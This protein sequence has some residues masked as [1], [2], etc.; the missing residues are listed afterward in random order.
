[1]LEVIAKLVIVFTSVAGILVATYIRY[2]KTAHSVLVCPLHSSCE[3]VTHSQFSYF[4]GIPVELLGIGYYTLVAASYAAFLILPHL[5]NSTVVFVM[6]TLSMAA[7]MFS[8]YLT[9]IQAFTLKQWCTWCLFS[10]GLCTIIFAMSVTGSDVSLG[11]IL[12]HNRG[13]ILGLHLFGVI[14]GVG[15]ASITDILFFKFIKDFRISSD[16][17]T[18]ISVVSQ[19]IWFGLAILILSGI[20]LYLP[21]ADR[22]NQSSK[23]L[24]KVVAV[25][26]ILVN[27]AFL[28]LV[29]AP[30][31]IHITFGGPHHHK[32]GELKHLRKVA[33]ALGA[34]SITSWYCAFILGLIK[35]IPLSFTT[36]VSVFFGVLGVAVVISQLF[37]QVMI[38]KN[39]GG[40]AGVA[41]QPRSPRQVGYQ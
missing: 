26:V 25:G 41:T 27:G 39:L 40:G 7:F 4:L 10:A 35:S 23:F 14:L 13:I 3:A 38:R 9:F 17:A 16:E 34:I 19:I 31:L 32:S 15:G 24:V 29:V 21:E 30:R 33:Y 12:A 1:M 2:K 22:F 18:I 28:N 5:A 37:E 20:G 36:L 8:L 11:T 6:L